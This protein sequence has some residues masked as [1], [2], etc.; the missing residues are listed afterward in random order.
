MPKNTDE[1]Q[2]ERR[3]E[4]IFSAIISTF[5]RLMVVWV[6]LWMR[7]GTDPSG[8]VSKVLLILVVLD[9]GS[10]IPIW[11]SLKVRL[12]EIQGGEEDAAAQY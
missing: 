9:L 3:K 6:L 10:L 5:Y 4:A 7:S 8:I 12:K 11:I 2:A 1:R